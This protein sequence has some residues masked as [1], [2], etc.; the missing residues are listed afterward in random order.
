MKALEGVAME[1][2]DCAFPLLKDIVITDD[3]NKAMKDINWALLVGAKP[4]GAGMERS[5]LIRENGPIF[6]NTGKA[7]N[8]YA[9]SDVRIVVVGNPCNTNCLITMHN[10]PDVPKDRFQAMTN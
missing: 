6:V 1:L 5:D 2:D 7:I 9:S 8:Q 4:R 3:V 10:A